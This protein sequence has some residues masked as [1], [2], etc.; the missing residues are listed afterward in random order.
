M[1]ITIA[2][3]RGALWQWDT[4][5]VNEQFILASHVETNNRNSSG[6]LKSSGAFMPLASPVGT[7]KFKLQF[8]DTSV[9]QTGDK[10]TAIGV[11]R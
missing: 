7:Y 9:I 1:T 5:E 11:R 6:I 3:G 2:D 4:G 10:V 8:V